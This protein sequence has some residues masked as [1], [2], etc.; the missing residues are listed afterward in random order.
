MREKLKVA[1]WAH[2]LTDGQLIL[3]GIHDKEVANARDLGTFKSISSVTQFVQ[4]TKLCSFDDCVYFV[5]PSKP[6]TYVKDEIIHSEILLKGKGNMIKSCSNT[7]FNETVN[8]N[9]H[10]NSDGY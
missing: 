6:F 1:E 10:N 5:I 4:S 2:S 3:D 9:T 7:H 8:A